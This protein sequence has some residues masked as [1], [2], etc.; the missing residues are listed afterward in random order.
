MADPEAIWREF[1]KDLPEF[2]E[3]FPDEA[4]C[5]RFLIN[6]RWGKKPRCSKCDTDELWALKS[7][8]FECS[9]CGRQTS[10]TA[11]T[12]LHGT[13]KPVKMWFRAI[14]EMTTHKGGISAKDLQRIMGF[15][16]YQTAWSWLHKLRSCAFFRDRTPLKGA[17]QLD[18]GYIGGRSQQVGRP[19]GTKA[20][21]LV[22][23]EVHGR[24]RIEHSPDWRSKLPSPLRIGIWKILVR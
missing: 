3:T 13:R 4:S 21:V 1:P 18:D 23:V 16:S 12:P 6:L 8:R 20:L 14:W 17:V 11:G 9:S 22:A 5:R 24:V 19:N 2:G 7:G 15:G 10:V